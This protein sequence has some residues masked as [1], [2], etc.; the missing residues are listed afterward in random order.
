MGEVL[1]GFLLVSRFLLVS[2]FRLFSRLLLLAL[3]SW[4]LTVSWSPG[5][6]CSPGLQAPEPSSPAVDAVATV[7]GRATG[8]CRC[9]GSLIVHAGSRG[10]LLVGD[11]GC[12]LR[13][14]LVER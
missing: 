13:S 4:F 11:Q 10:L 3:V 8:A 7:H 5:F 2:W 1:P 12:P 9:G 14:P 6:S